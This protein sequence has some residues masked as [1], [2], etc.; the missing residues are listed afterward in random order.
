MKDVPQMHVA[1]LDPRQLMRNNE[2]L[3]LCPLSRLCGSASHVHIG[4]RHVRRKALHVP[5]SLVNMVRRI[6]K[7]NEGT[8]LPSQPHTADHKNKKP[9]ATGR[10]PQQITLQSTATAIPIANPLLCPS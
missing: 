4:S 2:S 1:I 10:K 9:F 3:E 6:A 5:G 7:L 8:F